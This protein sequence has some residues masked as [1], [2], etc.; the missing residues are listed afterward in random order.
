MFKFNYREFP[1]AAVIS[2]RRKL[3]KH[4]RAD[5]GTSKT[6]GTAILNFIGSFVSYEV[7]VDTRALAPSER[8]LLYNALGT[9]E[10]E[11]GIFEFPFNADTYEFEGYVTE[12][13]DAVYRTDSGINVWGS[14]AFTVNPVRKYNWG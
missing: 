5:T 11:T 10:T 6:T 8:A 14:I 4:Q 7:V 1:E 13:S 9:T 3:K 12:I 2:C